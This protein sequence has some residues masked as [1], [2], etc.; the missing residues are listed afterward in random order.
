LLDKRQSN[1][2]CLINDLEALYVFLSK[3]GKVRN[4]RVL[5][6]TFLINNIEGLYGFMSKSGK[7]RRMWGRVELSSADL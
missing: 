7:R 3:K 2:P 1:C 4:G 6:C 5:F